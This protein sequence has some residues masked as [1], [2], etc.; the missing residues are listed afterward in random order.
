MACASLPPK[1]IQDTRSWEEAGGGERSC[2]AWAPR[3]CAGRA[4]RYCPDLKVSSSR[5]G[6]TPGQPGGAASAR[7]RSLSVGRLPAHRTPPSPTK[8]NGVLAAGR[9]PCQ[10]R[11]RA[12]RGVQRMFDK[13]PTYTRQFN[14]QI[15]QEAA[16]AKA[17]KRITEG[18]SYAA[19]TLPDTRIARVISFDPTSRANMGSSYT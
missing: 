7:G 3:F 17:S 1:G 18:R 16:A 12:A 9:A 15:T 13:T 5:S 19:M 10:H 11:V 2:Q 6:Q 4:C 8:R 14:T